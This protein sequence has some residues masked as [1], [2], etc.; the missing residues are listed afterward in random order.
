MTR[1]EHI[2]RHKQLHRALDE[3][4]GDWITNSGL[5]RPYPSECT[6]MQLMEWS[7]QQTLDP[8]PD[9]YAK[10]EKSS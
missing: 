5:E 9:R 3:L 6:I 10:E 2:E 8:T 7:Y 4:L 1:E